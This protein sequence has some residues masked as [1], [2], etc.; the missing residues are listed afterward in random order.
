M[1]AAIARHAGAR[2]IVVTD[3]SDFRLELADAAGADLVVN[4]GTTRLR[5]VQLGLGM[6][7]G[8]DI[9][10]E[11]SGAPQAVAEMIDN[12]N[13]REGGVYVIP[14]SFPVVPRGKARIRVQLSAAH[15]TDDVRACVAA[16]VAARDAATARPHAPVPPG[17]RR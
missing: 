12:M 17:R 7:E 5:D 2:N 4:S 10:L 14:F 6:K 16:F 1:A 9:G 13:Q 15:S 11:M 8:F 3:L